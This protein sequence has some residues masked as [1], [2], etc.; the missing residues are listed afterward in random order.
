MVA[1]AHVRPVRPRAACGEAV[2][3]E[4]PYGKRVRARWRISAPR[5]RSRAVSRRNPLR[6][7]ASG[8]RGALVTG[9]A[10]CATDRSIVRG[11]GAHA[12]RTGPH[13]GVG[14]HLDADPGR[15]GR[16]HRSCRSREGLR[17][18]D[19]SA[20]G[21]G[22]RKR[23]LRGRRGWLCART[24]PA[25]SSSVRFRGRAR[26]HQSC[27]T[28][29][30]G[31]NVVKLC[32]Q[33]CANPGRGITWRAGVTSTARRRLQW[34]EHS[35]AHRRH[36]GTARAGPARHLPRTP[37]AGVSDSSSRFGTPAGRNS[38][39]LVESSHPPPTSQ[40]R[41]TPPDRRSRLVDAH[42]VRRNDGTRR[43]ATRGRLFAGRWGRSDRVGRQ[44]PTTGLT[45]GMV[46]ARLAAADHELAGRALRRR[47]AW[48][49]HQ[50]AADVAPGVG[51]RPRR[52]AGG[53]QRGRELAPA[54][55]VG[56][57][58][59]GRMTLAPDVPAELRA[60]ADQQPH[61]RGRGPAP[62]PG[63]PTARGS[64]ARCPPARPRQ[65]RRNTGSA[66]RGAIKIIED[67]RPHVFIARPLIRR[68]GQRPG[69]PR[70]P[71]RRAR[72]PP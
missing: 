23:P 43:P 34:H 40:T 15:R 71:R 68:G 26:A 55:P 60:H 3:K 32:C 46:L 2:P 25:S 45:E 67:D 13:F 14:E 51:A 44:R 11:S 20:S 7:R 72:C 42:P 39:P 38:L 19:V 18:V 56:A 4:L 66:L 28:R 64:G 59:H 36:R 10:R 16:A 61:C 22:A 49:R 31:R 65:D 17:V 69:G 6:G 63:A 8:A 47:R 9:P 1:R 27:V 30:F 41:L 58:G 33:T 21:A 48:R 50:G 57:L 52:G 35:H 5:R 24:T 37:V 53:A 29:F 54:W 62:P 70:A 12:A